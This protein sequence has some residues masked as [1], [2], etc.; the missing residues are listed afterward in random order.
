[1]HLRGPGGPMGAL[2]VDLD[3]LHGPPY[4][5][6]LCFFASFRGSWGIP[7]SFLEPSGPSNWTTARTLMV[8]FLLSRVSLK[9]MGGPKSEGVLGTLNPLSE[10]EAS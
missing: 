1:M 7:E 8:Q 5:P 10:K 6:S 4:G 9:R 3:A 2:R